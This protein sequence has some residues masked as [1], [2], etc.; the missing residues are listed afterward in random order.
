MKTSTAAE[1][2]P[3]RMVKDADS[4][5]AVGCTITDGWGAKT[6]ILKGSGRVRTAPRPS[7]HDAP[8]IARVRL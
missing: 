2:L 3:I 4:T 8:E 6:E 1:S 5:K 7:R